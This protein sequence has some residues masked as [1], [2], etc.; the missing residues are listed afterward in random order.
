MC[1]QYPIHSYISWAW[2][3]WWLA[4]DSKPLRYINVPIEGATLHRQGLRWRFWFETH[5]LRS[6]PFLLFLSFFPGLFLSLSALLFPLSLSL[7]LSYFS[8]LFVFSFLSFFFFLSFFVICLLFFPFF[9]PSF[10]LI[11]KQRYD[12]ADGFD[13]WRVLHL[14]CR[15]PGSCS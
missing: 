11:W 5:L 9:C 4:R 1:R 8:F 10:S 14:P 7:S 12:F 3:Y 6:L 13:E 2:V 15:S